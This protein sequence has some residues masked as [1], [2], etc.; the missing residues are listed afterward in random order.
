MLS[1]NFSYCLFFLALVGLLKFDMF[2]I[3]IG[4]SDGYVG[5]LFFAGVE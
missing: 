5:G 1:S 3:L 2:F 4:V